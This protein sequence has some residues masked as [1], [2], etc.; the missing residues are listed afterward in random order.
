M[1]AQHTNHSWRLIS[2]DAQCSPASVEQNVV[3]VEC[4]TTNV[5]P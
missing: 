5:V 2:L 3:S 4:V 1:P